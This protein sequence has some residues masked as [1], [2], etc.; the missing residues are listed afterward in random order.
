ML[1]VLVI[2]GKQAGVPPYLTPAL[3]GFLV[4]GIGLSLGEPIGYA[5][6]PARGL[7]PRIAHQVLPIPEKGFSDRAYGATVPI[8][9]PIVGALRFTRSPNLETIYIII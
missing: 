2:T 7:S 4:W 5:I 3:V 1:G 9:G 8:F 6:N